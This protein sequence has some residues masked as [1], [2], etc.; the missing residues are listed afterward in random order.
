M[1]EY[2]NKLISN[3]NTL[4]KLSIRF[5]GLSLSAES[6]ELISKFYTFLRDT[7]LQTSVLVDLPDGVDIE[8][9]FCP[10]TT[11]SNL[12]KNDRE[13]VNLLEDFAYEIDEIVRKIRDKGILDKDVIIESLPDSKLREVFELISDEKL[14]KIKDLASKLSEKIKAAPFLS[15]LW[16]QEA[17]NF[18]LQ[19][20]IKIQKDKDIEQKKAELKQ[21]KSE[22]KVSK[23]WHEYFEDRVEEIKDEIDPFQK[24]KLKKCNNLLGIKGKIFWLR[25]LIYLFP[26]VS[27]YVGYG[28]IND[29]KHEIGPIHYELAVSM[30]LIISILSYHLKHSLRELNILKQMRSSYLHRA[31]VAKTFQSLVAT[32]HFKDEKGDIVVKEAALAMFKRESQGYLSK[33]QL[34][35]SNTPIQDVVKIFNNK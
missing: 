27:A 19:K 24:T 35:P 33:D 4:R 14:E 25:F 20:Q 16:E 21:Q 7:S 29:D 3:F 5:N 1:N 31:I 12:C 11:Y 32:D 28:I 34:E 18:L 9:N 15:S 13:S 23:D 10:Y 6:R 2:L 8:D 26:L 22:L 17:Q 30:L